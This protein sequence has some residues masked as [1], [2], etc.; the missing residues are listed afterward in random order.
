MLSSPAQ[1]AMFPWPLHH[2][3]VGG[4]DGVGGRREGGMGEGV[5]LTDILQGSEVNIPHWSP[6]KCVQPSC[7][8]ARDKTSKHSHGKHQQFTNF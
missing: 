3:G 2:P 7:G 1:A 6:T 4:S 8:V 5:V